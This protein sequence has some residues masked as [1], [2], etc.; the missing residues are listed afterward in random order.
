MPLKPGTEIIHP[1]FGEGTVKAQISSY[2]YRV[3]FNNGKTLVCDEGNLQ[4]KIN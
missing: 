4:E 2:R 3:K 1:A